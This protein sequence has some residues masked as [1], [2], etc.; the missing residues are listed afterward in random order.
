M[1]DI[2]EVLVMTQKFSGT[3]YFMFVVMLFL[4]ILIG[5]YFGFFHKSNNNTEADYLMG[6]RTMSVIP[7]AL[8]L[9]AR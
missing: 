5:I 6:G 3:D 2:E 7:I 9:L 8:S 1:M 4:C